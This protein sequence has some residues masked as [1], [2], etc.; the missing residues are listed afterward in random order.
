MIKSFF[1][2]KRAEAFAENMKANGAE[3]VE[4]WTDTDGFGQRIYIVKWYF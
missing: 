3:N 4:V 1:G 2:K